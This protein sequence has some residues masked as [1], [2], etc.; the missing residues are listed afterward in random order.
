MLIDKL[1]CRILKRKVA[2]QPLIDHRGQGVLIAGQADLTANLL[3]RHVVKRAEALLHLDGFRTSSEQR[4]AK[5]AEEHPM[6]GSYEQ[7]FGFE[8]TVEQMLIVGELQGRGD[9][10]RVGDYC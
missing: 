9:G 4:Q 10:A 1:R 7:V 3:R 6:F 2:A 8:I 5:I